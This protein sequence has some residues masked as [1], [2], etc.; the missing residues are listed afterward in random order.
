MYVSV[1]DIIITIVPLLIGV[2]LGSISTASI[3]HDEWG[4][5]ATLV[6]VPVIIWQAWETRRAVSIALVKEQPFLE[7]FFPENSSSKIQLKNIGTS[8]AYA[9]AISSVIISSNESVAFDPLSTSKAPILPGETRDVWVHHR[10]HKN[11]NPSLVSSSIPFLI[12]KNFLKQT[13]TSL[14]ISLEY[15]DKDGHELKRSLYIKVS[16]NSASTDDHL[17]VSTSGDHYNNLVHH[18]MPESAPAQKG[19]EI[20]VK[21][22]K[23]YNKL[24]RDNI[25]NIILAKEGEEAMWHIASDAEYWDKLIEKVSEEAAE[26]RA[27]ESIE[28]FA[29]LMEVVDAIAAHKGFAPQEVGRIRAEKNLKRGAF[30]KKIILD[31]AP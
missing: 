20:A 24:V 26:L 25:P 21:S 3:M 9:V 27:D 17:Y 8:P 28:E 11:D 12:L 23:K 18:K 13:G 6:L 10:R 31:E 16:G 1:K 14:K 4:V 22:T 15:F 29:D 30:M 7:L 19:K 5:L 2:G